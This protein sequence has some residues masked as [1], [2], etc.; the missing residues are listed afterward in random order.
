MDWKQILV[1]IFAAI[2]AGALTP[3]VIRW[4]SKIGLI[5]KNSDNSDK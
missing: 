3:V 4:L 5:K 1:V 2:I